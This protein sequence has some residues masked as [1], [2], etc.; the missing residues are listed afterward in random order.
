MREGQALD[1][2]LV[3]LESVLHLQ[4]FKVPDNNVS[5]KVVKV[6]SNH[7]SVDNYSNF[8]GAGIFQL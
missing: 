4:R 7:H 3:Q 5:L 1:E 8:K 2:H 6:I